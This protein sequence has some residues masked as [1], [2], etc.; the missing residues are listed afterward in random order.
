MRDE[1]FEGTKIAI[2]LC[3]SRL[4]LM[5][6]RFVFR[7]CC[8]IWQSLVGLA[9]Y[10]VPLLVAVPFFLTKSNRVKT[11]ILL[12][13]QWTTQIVL[14]PTVSA[15]FWPC[16]IIISNV[17]EWERCTNHNL[18]GGMFQTDL[19]S[20]RVRLYP[21]ERTEET[22]QVPMPPIHCYKPYHNFSISGAIW[23]WGSAMIL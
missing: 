7:F 10:L 8:N 14:P 11:A 21:T 16:L 6:P 1:A 19:T 4:D 15:I 12:R 17:L 22:C 9:V 13:G 20:S 23:F 3:Q 5:I 18:V 2:N